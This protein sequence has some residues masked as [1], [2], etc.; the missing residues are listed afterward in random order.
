[1]TPGP[2]RGRTRRW[3]R[4]LSPVLAAAVALVAVAPPGAAAPP[5]VGQLEPSLAAVVDVAPAQSQLRVIVHFRD[6][7]PR[8]IRGAGHQRARALLTALRAQADGSQLPVDP[9]LKRWHATGEVSRVTRLWIRNAIA[10]S[11][12]PAVVRALARL[13]GVETVVADRAFVLSA[14]DL[15]LANASANA[16]PGSAEPNVSLIGAP[17]VWAMGARG[18]GVVVASMD[19]GVDTTNPD[20]AATYRGG[21][22]SWYDPNGEHPTGPYDASGHGTWTTGVMVGGADGGTSVG[23]AP[24]AKWVAVKMFSDA[25]VAT[26]SG[27]HLGFQWLLD[28]DNDPLTDDAPD[29]VNNSWSVIGGGCDL[30]FERDLAVLVA[31]GIVPVVAA[32]NYGPG[33]G[34]ATSPGTDP[35]AF[36]V[37]ASDGDAIAS[38]SGRGPT[39]CGRPGPV[40]APSVVAP[41]V[42]VRTTDRFGLYTTQSGTSLAA[43]HVSGALALL[44]GAFPA[45]SIADIESALLSTATDLGPAGPDDAAG[46]GRINVLAAYLQLAPAPT[47][48]PTPPVPTPTPP[49][50]T[51]TPPIPTP[52]PDLAG[53]AVS[54]VLAAP[55]PANGRDNVA[56]SATV[57]DTASGASPIVAAEAFIDTAGLP[58][59]GMALGGAFGGT[60]VTVSG[61]LPAAQLASASEGVHRV[62]VRGLD[63]AGQWGPIADTALVLDR[64]APTIMSL[65]LLPVST[66]AAASVSVAAEALD[67]STTASG[68]NGAEWFIGPDPGPGRGHPLGAVDGLF[69]GA[70]EALAGAVATGGLPYGDQVAWVRAVDAA[71]N[72]GPSVARS[73]LVTPADVIF[74]DGFDG[75]GLGGWSGRV[76]RERLIVSGPAALTGSMGLLATVSRS[77]PAYLID[78]TPRREARYRARFWFS[79]RGTLTAG[80]SLDILAGRDSLGRT[81]FRIQ[82]RRTLSG[83][84]QLRAVTLRAGGTSSTAWTT[85]PNRPQSVEVAWRA[86]AAG[87]ISLEIDGRLRASTTANTRGHALETVLLGPSAGFGPGAAGR[88]G[89]D[90][91][92]S[93]R[94]TRIGP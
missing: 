53:P 54:N 31:A 23:V 33:T 85:I 55:D 35:S 27:V 45:R 38:F 42:V 40:I 22:N 19:T 66:R 30:E 84:L 13:P 93:A 46:Y 74:A 80:R 81:I 82:Y 52:T 69:G 21:T 14:T 94:S 47:P 75:G 51:P 12:R 90:G 78:S 24:D 20:L 83:S 26:T 2:P 8:A 60:R 5:A 39:S 56:L 11:A 9:E 91:F 10:V 3:Q 49:I 89:F 88:L 59:S 61:L 67:P 32:G 58:G 86:A 87:G 71:G 76:G 43:P 17:D 63:G 79:P 16:A 37:G 25:G 72:W 64:S 57:D 41:G 29:I 34:S 77:L 70:R 18:A 15:A 6:V 4:V 7:D 50:P 62:L 73:F 1:M 48:T 44:R 92:V 28:P 36:A 68:V 65:T